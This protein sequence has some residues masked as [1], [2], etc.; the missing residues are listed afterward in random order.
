M[1]AACPLLAG[2]V[3]QSSTRLFDVS[4]TARTLPSEATPVGRRMAVALAALPVDVK[5]GWPTTAEALPTHTGHT[6]EYGG[7]SASGVGSM[8][9]RLL[10]IRTRLLFGNKPRRFESLTNSVLAA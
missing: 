9:D 2:M 5:S 4:A 7:I 10:K 8:P 6:P 3:F 1:S